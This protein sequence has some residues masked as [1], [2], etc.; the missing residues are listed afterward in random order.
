MITTDELRLLLSPNGYGL[1][2]C[3]VAWPFCC[4]GGAW[5]GVP[6][7]AAVWCGVAWPWRCVAHALR[8]D[9]VWC[10]VSGRGCIRIG[11]HICAQHWVHRCHR[12][13][14][15]R[16]SKIHPLRNYGLGDGFLKFVWEM[17]STVIV[18]TAPPLDQVLHDVEG[19]RGSVGSF[20][21]R[22][23][24]GTITISQNLIKNPLH[25][26]IRHPTSAGVL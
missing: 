8:C 12:T 20:G 18:L 15:W 5:C 7:G 4:R 6:L 16:Q 26:G 13:I 19:I 10:G 2:C 1:L 21:S 11:V 24:R 3:V 17:L 23:W 9:V 22:F 25:R 14:Q